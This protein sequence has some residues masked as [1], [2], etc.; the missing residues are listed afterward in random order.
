M[1]SSVTRTLCVARRWRTVGEDETASSLAWSNFVG[2]LA[3]VGDPLPVDETVGATL[4]RRRLRIRSWACRRIDGPVATNPAPC[5]FTVRQP[6][7]ARVAAVRGRPRSAPALGRV[8]ARSVVQ[9]HADGDGRTIVLFDV[10]RREREGWTVLAVIGE[11]DLS[12]V[13]RV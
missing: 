4:R 9:G 13:P 8:T 7:A 10:Q 5:R 1:H 11:L 12:V 6:V 3:Q 2:E